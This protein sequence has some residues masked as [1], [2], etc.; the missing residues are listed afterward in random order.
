LSIGRV[1]DFEGLAELG[2]VMGVEGFIAG[3]H[4]KKTGAFP[5]D[6]CE[7]D[8]ITSRTAALARSNA[9]LRV[10]ARTIAARRSRPVGSICM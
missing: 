8:V 7:D 10:N 6:F 1:A 4:G 2:D 3:A 5:A 9:A